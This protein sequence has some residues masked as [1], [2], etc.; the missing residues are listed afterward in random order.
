M[1]AGN[2]NRKNQTM[3]DKMQ[4]KKGVKIDSESYEEYVE[5]FKLKRTKDDTF[6]PPEV[7]DAIKGW[8]VKEYGLEGRVI[9]RPFWPDADYTQ[10]EYP[11]GCVVID[12]PPF[13][14][15]TKICKWYLDQGIDFFLFANHVTLFRTL[16]FS[17]VNAVVTGNLIV[18]ENGARIP[19]SYLTNMGTDRV[20]VSGELYEIVRKATGTV[21]NT[22]NLIEFPA[23]IISAPRLT[24]MARMGMNYRIKNMTYWPT[25]ES[26]NIFGGGGLISDSEVAKLEIAKK[27][28]AD[29]NPKVQYHLSDK[30]LSEIRR[31]NEM[32]E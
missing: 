31:L 30:E 1:N 2:T 25:I 19:I 8:V 11:E 32:D 10:T 14:I 20:I 22:H 17:H 7:Y 6:T 13:S 24:K 15:Q 21:E 18:F 26:Y 16:K 23:N 3:S 12:N 27:K 5:K 28:I 9:I 29:A 4:P